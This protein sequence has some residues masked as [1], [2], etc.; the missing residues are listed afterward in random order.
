MDD[1]SSVPVCRSYCFILALIRLSESWPLD[2]L[3]FDWLA[4]EF[5]W[6]ECFLLCFGAP[7]PS[8]WGELLSLTAFSKFSQDARRLA[9]FQCVVVPSNALFGFHGSLVLGRYF[10]VQVFLAGSDIYD[11]RIIL[12]D[13]ASCREA[14]AQSLPSC[15]LPTK[16]ANG[17]SIVSCLMRCSD[18]W[19]GVRFSQTP[20]PAF[21]S[22]PPPPVAKLQK[23]T[24]YLHRLS[25]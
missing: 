15:L 3:D 20:S 21:A 16:V 5:G 9:V 11:V 23:M 18:S 17:K 12:F 4:D 25:M 19:T 10:L 22:P 1:R 8:F 2:F 14:L 7:P 24:T 13:T 6:F